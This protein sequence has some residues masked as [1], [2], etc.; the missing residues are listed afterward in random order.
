M[1]IFLDLGILWHNVLA[2]STEATQQQIWG[3]YEE[4]PIRL[5]TGTPR[6]RVHIQFWGIRLDSLVKYFFFRK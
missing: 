5:E 4:V 3:Q 1:V 2:I 6:R